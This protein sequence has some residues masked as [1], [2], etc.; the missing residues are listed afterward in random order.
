MVDFPAGYVL[1]GGKRRQAQLAQ[2]LA[3]RDRM[4]EAWEARH[5]RLHT[6][7]YIHESGIFPY[8]WLT[9]LVDLY[10]R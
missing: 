2:A 8:I 3:E 1:S 6:N 10:G 5:G 7:I 9:Y 4:I